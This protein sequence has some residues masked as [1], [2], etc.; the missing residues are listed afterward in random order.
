MDE[1]EIGAFSHYLSPKF[2]TILK[3]YYS[4][5][6]AGNTKGIFQRQRQCN[7]IYGL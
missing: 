1:T 4:E 3:K 2:I 5:K 6:N 7:E